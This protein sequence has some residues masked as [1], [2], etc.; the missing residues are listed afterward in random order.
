MLYDVKGVA[1]IPSIGVWLGTGQTSERV[2]S[3]TPHARIIMDDRQH[4]LVVIT[5][6]TDYGDAFERE[7]E[8]HAYFERFAGLGY[9]FGVNTLLYGMTH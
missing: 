5:H 8:N 3:Q 7:G 2:D 4:V 6:N 9:A 1:Q